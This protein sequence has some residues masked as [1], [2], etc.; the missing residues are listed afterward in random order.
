[1]DARKRLVL[2]R[3]LKKH[4]RIFGA[5]W[6][7]YELLDAGNELKLERW[8]KV[9][10]IRP[11]RQAYFEPE[12]SFQQ[13]KEKAHWL[14]QEEKGQK[15]TWTPLKKNAP[16]SWPLAYKELQ[17]QLETTAFKHVGLFPE[18]RINWDFIEQ[19]LSP[20]ASFLNLFAYTGA[21]SLSAR[22]TGASV[23]HCDSVKQLVDWTNINQNLSG[24]EGIR[25]VLDDAMTF[26]KREV[27]RGNKYQMVQMDPPAFGL[28]KKGQKWKI[29]NK[30][31]E[32]IE[33]AH[34][35]LV[36]DGWLILN[37]YSPRLPFDE[38]LKLVQAKYS[39]TP[40]TAAQLWLKT[41]F[42]NRIYTGDLIR[43]QR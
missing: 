18:Q 25:W 43:V 17:F 30:I 14:F 13:W 10:T 21:S 8:G 16:E 3:L 28:G 42:G 27:K 5:A 7:D 41:S 29:E 39:K 24:L 9:V 2:A 23:T 40:E 31:E 20:D 22:K 34:E 37:T 4:P 1:M 12:L 15:G 6:E 38:L 11:E 26:A 36:P 32:L 19:H 33:L 35:L